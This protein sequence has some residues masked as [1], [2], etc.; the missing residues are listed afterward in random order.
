MARS[1]PVPRLKDLQ[2]RIEQRVY[3]PHDALHGTPHAVTQRVYTFGFPE[4]EAEIDQTDYGH[5]GR[6]NPCHARRIPAP[7]QPRTGQI[8]AAAEVLAVLLD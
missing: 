3:P 2:V 7:L 8:L 4:G 1:E 6:F 5:P